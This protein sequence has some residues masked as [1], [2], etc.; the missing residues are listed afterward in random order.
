MSIVVEI[1]II[2]AV[3]SLS[4]IIWQLMKAKQ[5]N[6]FKKLLSQDLKKQVIDHIYADLI[7]TRNSSYPNNESHQRATI[8]YWTCYKVRILQAALIHEIIDEQWLRSTG[9]WRNSQHLFHIENA[10]IAQVIEKIVYEESDS[11]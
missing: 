4:W 10:H 9:N 2:L 7:S 3:L 6:R 8:E 5:F 1:M 11:K